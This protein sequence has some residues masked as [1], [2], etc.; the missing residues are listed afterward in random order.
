MAEQIKQL[1]AEK[2]H[3]QNNPRPPYP[4][5]PQVMTTALHWMIDTINFKMVPFVV[6]TATFSGYYVPRRSITKFVTKKPRF[7]CDEGEI[8]VSVFESSEILNLSKII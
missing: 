5:V 7:Y 4:K 6:P 3:Q 8:E 1:S 2:S